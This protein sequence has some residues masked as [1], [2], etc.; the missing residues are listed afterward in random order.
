M[1]SL[2]RGHFSVAIV[3]KELLVGFKLAIFKGLK[4]TYEDEFADIPINVTRLTLYAR[5]SHL[6]VSFWQFLNM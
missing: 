3:F 1:S 5:K 2:E 6:E 4:E